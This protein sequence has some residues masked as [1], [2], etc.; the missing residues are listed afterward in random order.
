[1]MFAHAVA[2]GTTS[3]TFTRLGALHHA[4]SR[5]HHSQ[6][7]IDKPGQEKIRCVHSWPEHRELAGVHDRIV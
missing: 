6:R 5:Q 1:M 7:V 3:T 4:F 2:S